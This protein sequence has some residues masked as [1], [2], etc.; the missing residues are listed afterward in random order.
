M[1]KQDKYIHRI[2][3]LSLLYPMIKTEQESKRLKRS[4]KPAS[5]SVSLSKSNSEIKGKI[6]KKVTFKLPPHNGL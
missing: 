1:Y 5:V 2:T 4:F 6:R 3:E